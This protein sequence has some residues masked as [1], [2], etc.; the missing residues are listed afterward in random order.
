[1]SVDIGLGFVI[2]AV[3]ILWFVIGSKGHWISKAIVIFASLYFCLSV[4]FSIKDYMGWPTSED[5]PEKFL[6][7]WLI[8]EEP[9]KRTGNK[10]SIYAWLKPL[11]KTE[12]SYDTWGDYLLSFYDGESRPRAYR[13]DYSRDL[14]E[15]AQRAI[16]LLMGGA[17]VGGL[18]AGK[19][20]E[21]KGKGKGKAKG[22]GKGGGAANEG[23]GS[24]TRNGGIMFHQL[25]PPRLP[26]KVGG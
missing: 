25:P 6:V 2:V 12:K 1:M 9:D 16:E 4:G 17:R 5:L 19:E 8:I 15:K 22:Q 10:G 24:L 18:N 13:L 11:S 7:H 3:L 26:D 23:G 14:H 20:G 21:G